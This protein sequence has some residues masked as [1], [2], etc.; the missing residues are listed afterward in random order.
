[1]KKF[2][3]KVALVTGAGG[4]IGKAIVRSFAQEGA[5]VVAVDLKEEFVTPLV[6]ELKAAGHDV[7]GIAANVAERA[8]VQQA[9]DKALDTYGKVDIMA[10]NAGVIRIGSAT[11]ITD[12]D[13]DYVMNINAKGVF[14]CTQIALKHMLP[15]KEGA[16]INTASIAGK[17]GMPHL[18]HY[19]ASKFAVIGYTNTVARE[20]A[21]SGVTVNAICPGIVG[22]GMWRGEDGMANRTKLEGETE[23]QSWERN[24]KFYIPQGVEQTPEDIAEG[25]LY[26]A[27]A[28]HVTGQALAVDG[29]T[30][31]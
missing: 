18:S 28:K 7:I 23:E 3:G 11:D 8:S 14:I 17:L 1:M 21:S 2:E 10:N 6:E 25:V 20:V 24:K 16:I 12:E 13:W 19:C 9:F 22:T 27:G 4:G 30:T 5:K 31:L 29:G 15:R 26:L